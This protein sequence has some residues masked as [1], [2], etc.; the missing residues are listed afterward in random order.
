MLRMSGRDERPMTNE[1]PPGCE[2]ARRDRLIAVSGQADF[3]S[4]GQVAHPGDARAQVVAVV[5]R[6]RE[7]I[8]FAAGSSHERRARRRAGPSG[9]AGGDRGDRDDQPAAKGR[10]AAS[11]AS[12]GVPVS[13]GASSRTLRCCSGPSE[14]NARGRST[15][16]GRDDLPELSVRRAEARCSLPVGRQGSRHLSSF[17]TADCDLPATPPSAGRW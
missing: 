9:D 17:H 6:I 10:A 8:E 14:W 7:R 16:P 2:V 15:L 1:A 11:S 4:F 13:G 12:Q 5:G 3:D